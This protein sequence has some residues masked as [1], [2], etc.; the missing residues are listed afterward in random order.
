MTD[1]ELQLALAKM[2]PEK[3]ILRDFPHIDCVHWSYKHTDSEFIQRVQDTEWLHVCWLAEKQLSDTQLYNYSM[4]LSEIMNAKMY[5]L[6]SA[7]WQQKA[8]ALCR[9][10]T[11]QL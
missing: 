4:F 9:L 3:F 2:L 11:S 5:Q 1:Q 7:S 10:K 8:E 6:I